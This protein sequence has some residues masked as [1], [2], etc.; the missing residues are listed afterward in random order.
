MGGSFLLGRVAGIEIRVHWSWFAIFL[1]LTWWLAEGFFKDVYEDWS[2]GERWGSAVVAALVFFASVL[3][4]ELS[5]S[6]TAR[7]LGLPVRSITLFIFGGVSALE[8][9]PKSAGQ[10]FRVAIVGPLTS[11]ALAG[12]FGVVALIAWA[13]DASGEPVG[14]I[15]EYLAF[16]NLAV[17]IFN[18]LPGY[19]LDG[20]R[21]LRAGLWA[22][23]GNLLAATRTAAGA[24]SA[25]AFGL[26]ALGGVWI[27]VGQF[28][29]GAWFIV[30]G[31][32]LRNVS[33]SSYRQLLF[34][35]TLGGT[36]VGE[37]VNRSFQAV[38][39]DI[40]LLQMVNDNMLGKGQRCVPIVAGEELLG[41][42][43]IADL[44]RVPQEQ[45]GTTSTY[46]A[47]TPKERLHVAS[48][49]DD[50]AMALEM[51]ATH[52]IH[53]MPVVEG[54]TFL[55]FVT[56]ADVLRLIQVRSELAETTPGT[57]NT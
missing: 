43:T 20:G 57:A 46:R 31:W 22:R 34:Q 23:G 8:G 24:G 26:M 12:V 19:P 30:I 9:E 14:A 35:S 29:S 15:A 36:T 3:L 21:V 51:M 50:V 40:P 7:R 32:F 33:E 1:L 16:I 13:S 28:A 44:K 27:I 47:M 10:E 37:V 41:L 55:G 48:P 42:V 11:F 4:H 52:D 53:Q 38:P 2:G 18:M 6:L 5:H 39:P 56:R 25:L 17:G 49:R 45:W 54:R